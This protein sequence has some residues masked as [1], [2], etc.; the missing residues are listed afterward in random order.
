M[1]ETLKYRIIELLARDVHKLHSISDISK[2]LNA[3]YS[4]THVF[5]KKLWEE[6]VVVI[7]KIGNVSVCKL[8]LKN[9]VTI[10]YLSLIESR[11]AAEWLN[12][13]PHSKKITERIEKVK[14]NIHAVLIKNNKVVLVVPER[15]SGADFSMF[16]NR[17][18]ISAREL[19]K[20]VN[21]LEEFVVLYGAEKYWSI[22]GEDA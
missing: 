14:D 3:A 7:E 17:T 9:P 10:S 16:R 2:K 1:T 21:V 13:N 18:V 22:R 19:N 12:K 15:I 11:R 20:K 6:N 8:N 4:H 5:I